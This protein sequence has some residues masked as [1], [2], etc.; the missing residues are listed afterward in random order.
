MKSLLRFQFQSTTIISKKSKAFQTDQTSRILT[1]TSVAL[2]FILKEIQTIEIDGKR[3]GVAI[4]QFFIFAGPILNHKRH[5]LTIG[6]SFEKYR[7][8]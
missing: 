7:S 8:L 5:V 6:F 4:K 3:A 2:L 1:V